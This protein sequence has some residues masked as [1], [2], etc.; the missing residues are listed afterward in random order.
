MIVGAT[1][2][3]IWGDRTI[4]LGG[5]QMIWNLRGQNN[6]YNWYNNIPLV[7]PNSFGPPPM[8]AV[9]LD[10]KNRGSYSCDVLSVPSMATTFLLLELVW[11]DNIYSSQGKKE[12]LLS[13]TAEK[14]W[15]V[16]IEDLCPA[17][18]SPTV[19]YNCPV[20]TSHEDRR[21]KPAGINAIFHSSLWY[22]WDWDTSCWTAD[23]ST[24]Y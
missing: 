20:K 7:P 3:G 4:I 6:C 22:H 21:A 1:R 13:A 24:W 17:E 9:G 12:H 23:L 8:G 18:G 10:F 2:N 15:M 11:E 16:R 5:R 14:V 19:W